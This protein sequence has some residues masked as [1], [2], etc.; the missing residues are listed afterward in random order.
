VIVSE[1]VADEPSASVTCAGAKLHVAATGSPAQANVT[2]PAGPHMDV[3]CRPN[4]E[5]LE[6]LVTVRLPV[7]GES[8]RVGSLA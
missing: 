7:E 1:V 6:P 4:G 3:T 8:V 2:G 5:E